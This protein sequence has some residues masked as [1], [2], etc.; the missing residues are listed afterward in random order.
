MAKLIEDVLV[1]KIS[2]LFKDSEDVTPVIT[3]ETKNA[4]EQ[5]ILEIV[6]EGVLVEVE[7]A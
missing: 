1:I 7:S 5:I 6:G 4:L 3:E 2:K